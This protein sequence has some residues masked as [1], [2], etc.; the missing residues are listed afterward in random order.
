[1]PDVRIPGLSIVTELSAYAAL[2]ASARA[3]QRRG[4]LSPLYLVS[5]RAPRRIAELMPNVRLIATLRDPADRAYSEYLMNVRN[6]IERRTFESAVRDEPPGDRDFSSRHYNESRIVRNGFYAHHLR[7]FYDH[8]PA[9][10]IQ[11]CL[12]EEIT[13]A[14]AP[15]LAALLGWLGADARVPLAAPRNPNPAWIPRSPRLHRWMTHP[16][17]L[18]RVLKAS[19]PARARAA[20]RDAVMR[21][22]RHTPPSQHTP[23]IRRLLVDRFHEDIVALEALIGRDLTAWRS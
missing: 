17:A 2:F 15:T 12:F 1:M 13:T 5:S 8:F 23:A 6:G 10:Q 16:N 4:E 19:M 3:D 18:R 14:P 11:V 20:L 21:R 22:N 7:R 9:G